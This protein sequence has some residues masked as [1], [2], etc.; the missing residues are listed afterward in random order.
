MIG[1]I[2]LDLINRRNNGIFAL[3]FVKIKNYEELPKL[4]QVSLEINTNLSD[5]LCTNL[6]PHFIEI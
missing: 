6:S 3:D 4:G 1:F 5:F 2:M